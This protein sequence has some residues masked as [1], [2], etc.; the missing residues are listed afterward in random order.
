[1][2]GFTDAGS[3]MILSYRGG[4]DVT[5]TTASKKADAPAVNETYD[6]TVTDVTSPT[7]TGLN[8]ETYNYTCNFH[9]DTYT[10]DA[11]MTVARVKKIVI[12]DMTADLINR[13]KKAQDTADASGHS[14]P[15]SSCGKYRRNYCDKLPRH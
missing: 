3:T 14:W 11:G 8:G 6:F 13:G 10:D 2:M 12:T 7:Y 9:I 4:E 5:K 15:R 1:V